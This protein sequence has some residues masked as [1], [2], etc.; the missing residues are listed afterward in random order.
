MLKRTFLPLLLVALAPTTVWA[1]I[2][3]GI[4]GGIE[5]TSTADTDDNVTEIAIPAD[6]LRIG[7]WRSDRR[8]VELRPSVS[9]GSSGGRAQT[10]LGLGAGLRFL[11]RGMDWEAAVP[12][13]RVGGGLDYFKRSDADART[14][15]S[16][17]QFSAGAGVGVEVPIAE[18]VGL[19]L[20]GFYVHG[21]P[22]DNF[23]K[24]DSFGVR[25]GLTAVLSVE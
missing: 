14:S 22:N 25:I 11:L 5:I 1:Q 3:F 2:E 19:R 9:R 10:E 8:I 12:F 21:F 16:A 20:E 4:D 17:T 7:I 24:F 18:P 6:G 23:A 15:D 13:V